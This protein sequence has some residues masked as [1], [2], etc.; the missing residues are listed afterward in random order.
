[1]ASGQPPGAKK[2]AITQEP[3]NLA[4]VL[5]VGLRPPAAHCH[6]RAT[7]RFP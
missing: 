2:R 6:V 4:L 7:E 5:T 3:P 1:M